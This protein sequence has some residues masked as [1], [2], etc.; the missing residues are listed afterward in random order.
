MMEVSPTPGPP[1]LTVAIPTYNRPKELREC[2][3]Y[4]RNQTDHRFHLLVIDN[5]SPTPA[6]AILDGLLE[7]FPALSFNVVRNRVNVGGDANVLRCFELCETEYLWIL[8]DDDAP[9]PTA[10]ETIHATLQEYPKALFVNFTCELHNRLAES[11]TSNLDEFIGSVDSFS[12][13]LFASTSVFRVPETAPHLRFAYR[14]S[15]AMAPHIILLLQA[16]MRGPG[17]C[18]L[19]TRRIVRWTA[20]PDGTR[21]SIV[22]QLLGVGVL[23]DM[24]LSTENRRRLAQILPRPQALECATIQLMGHRLQ[25]GDFVRCRYLLDQLYFRLLRHSATFSMRV[26]FLIYRNV[27]M[28]FPGMGMSL[29]RTAIKLSGRGKDMLTIRDPDDQA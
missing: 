6:S 2:V 29:F 11:T 19:S 7:D 1:L 20:P 9:L 3:E 25:S 10:V 12:N 5:A 18:Y 28:R 14:F 16:L 23:L 13:I 4:L 26:R 27:F 17:T 8:G 15:Y 24:P 21:W 22:A